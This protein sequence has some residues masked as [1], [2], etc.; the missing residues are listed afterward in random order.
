MLAGSIINNLNFSKNVTC[1][2]NFERTA[3]CS[4]FLKIADGGIP[5]SS[6]LLPRLV[7]VSQ[8]FAI[9][10]LGGAMLHCSL[11]RKLTADQDNGPFFAPATLAIRQAFDKLGL[12]LRHDR[13][14]FKV[15]FPPAR[16]PDVSRSRADELLNVDAALWV[17]RQAL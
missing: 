14:P 4:E 8:S 1:V 7:E 15:V 5:R 17:L 6:R 11:S 16:H 3:V 9:G 10:R 13:V 2:S 12:P